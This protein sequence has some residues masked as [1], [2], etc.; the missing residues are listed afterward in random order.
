MIHLKGKRAR[1]VY[2][3]Q[4]KAGDCIMTPKNALTAFALMT[5]MGLLVANA[6][7][8]APL[9]LTAPSS[10]SLPAPGLPIPERL[11][12]APDN[13]LNLSGPGV[14]NV[15]TSGKASTSRLAP[16]ANGGTS[17]S[18]AYSMYAEKWP[19]STARVAS[20]SESLSTAA[21]DNPVT[22]APYRQTGMLLMDFMTDSGLKTYQCSASLIMANVLVTAAHC[23]QDYGKAEAGKATN[24]RWIPA[25]TGDP[26]VEA[27]APFGVWTGESWVISDTYYNGKDTCA[28]GAVGIV[29][30]NDIALIALNTLNGK[31]AAEVLGDAYSYGYNGYS[32]VKSPAFKNLTVV[33]ITQLGYPA[34]FDNGL[35]MQRNNSFGKVVSWRGLRTT[36]R[37]V[38]LNTQLGT[39]LTAGSSGGPWLVNFGT[40]PVVDGSEASLGNYSDDYN[41]VVG[42]TSYGYTEVGV[43]IQ[44]ASYFGQNAE[45]P[46]AQYGTY[47]AGNIAALAQLLCTSRPDACSTTCSAKSGNRC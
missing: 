27:N 35:Q 34:A 32:Y 10:A 13:V 21:L 29:C 11:P 37:K 47:G 19:Y 31:R 36:T 42:V 22:A 44:G 45:Y 12:R 8:A 16:Q 24:I 39:S 14:D 28:R 23:V 41:V 38:L 1:N 43:N 15:T 6:Q 25:N 17:G 20:T 46:L 5:G 33:D 9:R 40:R 3:D 30:N 4:M 7:A 26:S 18:R 2:A